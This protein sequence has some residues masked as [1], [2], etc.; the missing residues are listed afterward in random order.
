MRSPSLGRRGWERTRQEEDRESHDCDGDDD[1]ATLLPRFEPWRVV[2]LD[3]GGIGIENLRG[4]ICL[5][6]LGLC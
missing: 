3:G 6:L 4:H 5:A 1:A 2:G